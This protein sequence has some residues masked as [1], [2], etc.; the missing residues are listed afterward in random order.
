MKRL[1]ARARRQSIETGGIAVETTSEQLVWES[2]PSILSDLPNIFKWL[3][4]ASL[5]ASIPF[6]VPWAAT[7]IP[8]PSAIQPIV[9]SLRR[10]IEQHSSDLSLAFMAIGVLATLPAVWAIYCLKVTRYRLTTERLKIQKGFVFRRIE[11][12][13]L[14]RIMDF[15]LCLPLH[16]RIVGQGNIVVVTADKTLPIV[17]INGVSQPENLRNTMRQ[18]VF[19]RRGMNRGMIEALR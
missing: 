19:E 6:A 1:Q 16:E 9:G 17:K 7:N 4:W 5:F 15:R 10:S 11:E 2:S 18:L 3:F 14:F 13:E 8:W 12:V